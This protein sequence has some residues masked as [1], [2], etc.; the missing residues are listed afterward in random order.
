MNLRDERG[1][2]LAEMLVSLVIF[3]LS[4][5]IIWQGAGLVSRL[6]SRINAHKAEMARIQVIVADVNARL[7]PLQPITDG[8]LTGRATHMEFQCEPKAPS[9]NCAYNAPLGHF[10]YISDGARYSDWPPVKVTASDEP[11]RLAAVALEN[12]RGKSLAVIKFPVEHAADCQFDMISRTCRSESAIS[13][14]T[15]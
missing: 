6:N 14:T 13:E 12:D 15:P 10:V 2:T 7:S 8:Q 1:F 5:A 4:M 3:S 11:V 9:E